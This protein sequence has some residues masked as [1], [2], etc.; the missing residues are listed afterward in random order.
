MYSTAKL[1]QLFDLHKFCYK[2]VAKPN[3]DNYNFVVKLN[4]NN[5]TFVAKS[6]QANKRGCVHFDTP[7]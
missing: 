1:Q 6:N 2:N 5:L 7:S 4:Q 3:Q